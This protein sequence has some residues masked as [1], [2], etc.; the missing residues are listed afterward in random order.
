MNCY[1]R[2]ETWSFD[3]VMRDNDFW[4][5]RDLD[6]VRVQLSG[7]QAFANEELSL[8]GLDNNLVGLSLMLNRIVPH[9]AFLVAHSFDVAVLAVV[10]YIGPVKDTLLAEHFEVLEKQPFF[11][12]GFAGCTAGDVG[13]FHFSDHFHKQQDRREKI[14]CPGKQLALVD[15]SLG[16]LVESFDHLNVVLC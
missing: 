12:D 5:Q 16:L 9:S 2:K 10:A 3:G 1:H 11:H 15:H 13:H 8:V 14:C 7:M 4:A 6:E